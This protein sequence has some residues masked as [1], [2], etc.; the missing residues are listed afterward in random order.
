MIG[1]RTFSLLPSR[2]RVTTGAVAVAVA[3]ARC[4][5]VGTLGWTGLGLATG[6]SQVHWPQRTWTRAPA[7]IDATKQREHDAIV[8]CKLCELRIVSGIMLRDPFHFL[9]VTRAAQKATHWSINSTLEQPQHRQTDEARRGKA[10]GG[11][12]RRFE[13]GYHVET[14]L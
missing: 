13:L 5:C 14:M 1:Q 8:L 12:S 7:T 6:S 11:K 9:Q 3:G 4:V 2:S 10:S